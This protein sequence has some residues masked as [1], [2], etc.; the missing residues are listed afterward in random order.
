MVA[1]SLNTVSTDDAYVN[2]HV[3][4]VA[5]RVAGQ[6][7]RVLVDD[8]ARVK[9][10]ALL[11]QLD[12]EPYQ[13]QVRIRQAAVESAQADLGAARAQVLGLEA[14]ARSQRWQLQMTIEQ[15]R[16]KVATLRADVANYVS[17]KA[18]RS[19]H[20]RAHG[21][22][23]RQF[24][25]VHSLGLREGGPGWLATARD[26]RFRPAFPGRPLRAK[27]GGPSRPSLFG[28]FLSER[29]RP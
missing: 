5:P 21:R 19:R 12:K 18:S 22:F 26:C 27:S 2:S 16:N 10:G 11:V 13:V 29:G 7:T 23:R 3:T 15:A 1:T 25:G 6:V 8:N 17:S 28:V 14:L 9:K 24:R 20:A 4:F